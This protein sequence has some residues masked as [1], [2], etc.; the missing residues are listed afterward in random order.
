MA[1]VVVPGRQSLSDDEFLASFGTA[2]GKGL[3]TTLLLDAA[4]RRD[5]TDVELALVVCFRFGFSNAHVPVLVSLAFAHWHQ[6]HEDV[7]MALG[8]IKSPESV[9]ALAHL[10]EWIPSYL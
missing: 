3:G 7:A 10:A 4:T 6:R 9:E 1:L 8:R 5:P 2:D